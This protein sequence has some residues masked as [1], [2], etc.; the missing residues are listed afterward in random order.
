LAENRLR[1]L[2]A[3]VGDLVAG[4]AEIRLQHQI[5]LA[6]LGEQRAVFRVESRGSGEFLATFFGQF[7]FLWRDLLV[8]HQLRVELAGGFV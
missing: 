3:E 7:E 5:E 6:R 2:R 1:G 8:G 4:R